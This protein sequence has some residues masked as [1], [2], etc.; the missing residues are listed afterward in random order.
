MKVVGI[1]GPI[2]SGKDTIAEYIAKKYK[3]TSIS[4]RDIVK[5]I[6]EKEGLEPNRE[7][8]QKVARVHRDIYG[9]DVFA[10][11]V[12]KKAI[13]AKGNI[14]LKEM[15]T[16]GDVEI[17]KRYFVKSIVIIH[18]DAKPETRFKRMSKRAR[19]GDPKDLQEFIKNEETEKKFGYYDS[20]KFADFR[21]ETDGSMEDLQQKIDETM[22]EV[23]KE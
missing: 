2:G 15:R 7:N 21:I 9:E 16:V 5:E 19:L 18:V 23:L 1:V 20:F 14:L 10:N 22:E 17:P 3:F 6:T 13:N 12:L 4:Y 11:L 8:M